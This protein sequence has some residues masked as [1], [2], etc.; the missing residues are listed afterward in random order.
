MAKTVNIKNITAIDIKRRHPRYLTCKT[1]IHYARL[2]NDI[3]ALLQDGL[4]HM[5]DSQRRN[6]SIS[7]ALY[8]EDLRSDTHLFETFTRIYMQMFGAY[9]P[10]YESANADDEHAEL[11]AMCF[12]LWHSCCAEREGRIANPTNDGIRKIADSLVRLWHEKRTTLPPNEEL[13]DCIYSEET[14]RDA[15]LVKTILIWLGRYSHLGRWFVNTAP[16]DDMK[17]LFQHADKDTVEYAA[18]CYDLAEQRIWPLSLAPQHIY[19][20]MIRLDMDDPE[21]ELAAAIDKLAYKPFGIY[22][23]VGSDGKT[24]KLKD[25]KDEVISVSRSDFFGNTKKLERENTH[26]AASFICLDGQWRLNG[27]C[28][29]SSPGKD[30]YEDYLEEHRNKDHAMNDYRGQYDGFIQQHGGEKLFFFEDLNHY[31]KWLQKELGIQKPD[32]GF[33]SDYK[34]TPLAVFFEDN[35]Q[36]TMC[37]KPQCIRHPDNPFYNKSIAEEDGFQFVALQNVCSPGMLLYLMEH[38][39]L[40]DALFNDMR[41]YQH[42]KMLMQENMEF[43]ARCMRRDIH[44]DKVFHKRTAHP[45]LHEDMEIEHR[46]HEKYPYEEF[47]KAIA[48]EKTILSKALKEWKVVRANNTTTV[49]RDVRKRQDFE[50]PT[51]RLYEAHLNLDKD[52]IQISTVAPY[53]G[54]VNAPAASALLY[55]VVGAGRLIN[56]FRKYAREMMRDIKKKKK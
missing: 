27:P 55:N 37:L 17:H 19:A 41:G 40:P 1:D 20:E 24:L 50:M 34:D 5:E 43:L 35:G 6:I 46:Y 33:F 31:G 39:L 44:S 53:V 45:K 56:N 52:E 14:Q 23:L 7:M 29:W 10:F 28:L 36:M 2:A 30:K 42:G 26:M 16:D 22:K 8:M 38:D 9:L 3:H 13:A 54:K 49:I 51:R 15:D 4:S 47:V 11:D 25:Y 48:K 21:D 18:D 32:L 12:M